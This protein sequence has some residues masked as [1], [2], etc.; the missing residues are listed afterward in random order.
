VLSLK[1]K[2]KKKKKRK[3]K[4][5]EGIDFANLARKCGQRDAFADAVA[6]V[7]GLTRQDERRERSPSELLAGVIDSGE[8]VE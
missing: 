4:A 3:K 8:A 2:K 6:T 5:K 1:K 7:S